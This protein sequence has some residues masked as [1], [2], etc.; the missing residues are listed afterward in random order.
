MAR[1]EKVLIAGFSGSGKS[2]LL[3]ILAESAATDWN[4]LDL[5]Q[6]LLDQNPI[7][8]SIQ[9]LIETLGW[10]KFRLLERQGIE[11]FLKSEGKGVLALGGGAFNPLLW[12]LYGAHP[13]IKFC[14]LSAPFEVCWQRIISDVDEPRPLA[15]KG[16]ASLKELFD[17]RAL[18]YQLIPWRIENNGKQTLSML[19]HEFWSELE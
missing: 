7:F 11:A 18:V 10:E 5:D 9:E 6:L 8:S 16:K 14:H 12:Q 15:L 17:T 13:K 2:S 3:S 1:C 19:A 4:F